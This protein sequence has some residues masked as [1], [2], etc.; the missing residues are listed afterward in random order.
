M[1][2]SRHSGRFFPYPTT[3][4]ALAAAVL[5]RCFRRGPACFRV[6][7]I[8]L[9]PNQ[10]SLYLP[11]QDS[12]TSC[13][14]NGNL[15]PPLRDLPRVAFVSDQRIRGSEDRKEDKTYRLVDSASA[16]CPPSPPIFSSSRRLHFTHTPPRPPSCPSLH[17]LFLRT[18]ST[19]SFRRL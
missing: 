1:E 18:I 9:Q 17:P 5:C 6:S 2:S 19:P 15:H 4:M 14:A 13:V 11:D 8:S 7:V 3:Y 12:I 16:L 10:P